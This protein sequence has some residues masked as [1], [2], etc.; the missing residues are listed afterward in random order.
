MQLHAGIM[1][2]DCV[3]K[4]MRQC[5]LCS[6]AV[7]W[8]IGQ[9]LAEQIHQVL[10][11]LEAVEELAEPLSSFVRF[12]VHRELL[13]KLGVKGHFLGQLVVLSLARRSNRRKDGK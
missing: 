11:V 7:L 9:H 5:F 2:P 8:N 4:W 10:S 13:E 3:E 1:V 6:N 12:R